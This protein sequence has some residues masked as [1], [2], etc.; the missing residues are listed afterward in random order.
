MSYSSSN[1][2]EMPDVEPYVKFHLRRIKKAKEEQITAQQ[3]AWQKVETILDIIRRHPTIQR[4]YLFGS[5]AKGDFRK[6]S[7]IDIAVEGLPSHEFFAFWGKLEE[8]TGLPIDLVILTKEK[9][10]LADFIRCWGKLIYEKQHGI[11]N[12]KSGNRE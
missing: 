3:K 5:L 9:T 7:D 6:G 10:P 4:A 8:A 11:K 1:E 12:S 2:R